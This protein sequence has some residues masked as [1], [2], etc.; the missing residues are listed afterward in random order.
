MER[1][2]IS[3]HAK[4]VNSTWKLA[5]VKFIKDILI[6]TGHSEGIRPD[7]CGC[8]KSKAYKQFLKENHIKPDYINTCVHKG[9]RVVE[10]MIGAIE[11]Y[12]KVLNAE[13][14]NLEK[15][16]RIILRLHVRI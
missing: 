11:T 1:Y 9:N 6:N 3:T 2:F 13:V 10:R 12:L 4:I 14:L 15:C 16:L 5:A 8:F 7:H